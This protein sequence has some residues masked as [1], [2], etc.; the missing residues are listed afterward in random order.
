MEKGKLSAGCR[1]AID[2]LGAEAHG[3]DER[4][5]AAIHR[6]EDPQ[7]FVAGAMALRIAAQ[8]LEDKANELGID[9][10]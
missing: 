7:A 5:I 9:L 1:A 2:V 6:H 3:Y 10:S 4:S 8:I